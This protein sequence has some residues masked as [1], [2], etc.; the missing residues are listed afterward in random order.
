MKRFTSKLV[1]SILSNLNFFHEPLD[2]FVAHLLP[3]ELPRFSF[4]IDIVQTQLIFPTFV[5]LKTFNR[6]LVLPVH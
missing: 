1:F 3:I 4:I 5:N 6:K 2:P